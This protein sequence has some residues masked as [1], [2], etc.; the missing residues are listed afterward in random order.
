MCASVRAHG[1]ETYAVGYHQG[2]HF[3]IIA[4]LDSLAV[5]VRLVHYLNGGDSDP[6]V[7]RL[8]AQM[9]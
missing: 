9:T 1:P 4:T 3:R 7:E 2:D 8:L 6:E 5:A